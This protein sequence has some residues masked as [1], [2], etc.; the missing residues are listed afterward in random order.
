MKANELRIK[1]VFL[2]Y[3]KYLL[4][5]ISN[6]VNNKIYIGATQQKLKTWG[7]QHK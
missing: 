1:F 6:L 4:Y 7:Q 3:W 2:N 5:K